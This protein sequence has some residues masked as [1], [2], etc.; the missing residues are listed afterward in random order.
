LNQGDAWA[1]KEGW[2]NNADSTY[3]HHPYRSDV[4]AWTDGSKG[5]FGM[6]PS[7]AFDDPWLAGPSGFHPNMLRENSDT[8]RALNLVVFADF[9]V[10]CIRNYKLP[11]SCQTWLTV[12]RFMAGVATGK[13]CGET[14]AR[15]QSIRQNFTARVVAAGGEASFVDSIVDTRGYPGPA[16]MFEALTGALP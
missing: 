16:A 7:T 2:E 15:S 8:G 4:S 13:D 3:A 14:L 10:R 1:A 9:T 6:L 11:K 5:W 12:R